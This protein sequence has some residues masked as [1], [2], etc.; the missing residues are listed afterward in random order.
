MTRF[1]LIISLILIFNLFVILENSS[2][3]E[4]ELSTGSGWTT[5]AKMPTPRS[6]A[7]SVFLNDNIYLMG[8]QDKNNQPVD[9]VE[10]YHVKLDKWSVAASLPIPLELADADIFNKKIYLVGGQGLNGTHSNDLFIYDPGTDR[11]HEGKPMPTARHGLTAH[12]VNGTLYVIGGKNKELMG[13]AH[14]NLNINEAYNPKTDSW[15]SKAPMPTPRH[16]IASA[17]VD[18][19]IYVIGGRHTGLQQT[20]LDNNEMYDP[21]SDTWT[22]KAPMPTN[23]SGLA[24]AASADGNV[25]VFG[26]ED[27]EKACHT[28]PN[29]S[30]I[31]YDNNEKYNPR[32]DQWTLESPMPTARNTPSVQFANSSMYVIGGALA[33]C[34]SRSDINEIFH[35]NLN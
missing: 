24:A 9:T 15:T 6:N 25:Y 1:V 5:G 23:R 19:K 2:Y 7:A 14:E 21:F 16:H 20:Q 32:I 31:V 26:G 28:V 4:T 8:G 12:F 29:S 11:W 18:G 13:F 35:V 33:Q 22:S 3:G 34:Q 17:V 27:L 10:V 30:R